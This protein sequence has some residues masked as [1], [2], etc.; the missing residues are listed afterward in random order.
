[1]VKGINAN[2]IPE[3]SFDLRAIKKPVIIKA[4]QM[5]VPFHIQTLE[6]MFSGQTGDYLLIGVRGERYP[7]QKDIFEETYKV[8]SVD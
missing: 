1:M 8:I 5:E 2:K 3:A 6:G 7:C 4:I